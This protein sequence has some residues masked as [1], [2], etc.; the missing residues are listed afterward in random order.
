MPLLPATWCRMAARL[1][2]SARID[3]VSPLKTICASLA[4]CCSME[5]ATWFTGEA[6]CGCDGAGCAG[7]GGAAT[8]CAG[9]GWAAGWV[10][11]VDGSGCSRSAPPRKRGRILCAYI[12]AAAETSIK[13]RRAHPPLVAMR[14]NIRF[15]HAI[16]HLLNY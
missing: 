2:F 11:T 16:A 9:T 5:G 8:G 14:A 15:K 4:G 10:G 7:T 12:G 1:E 13:A 3:S 6:A